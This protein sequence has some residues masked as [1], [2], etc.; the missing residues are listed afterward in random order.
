ML[1]VLLLLLKGWTTESVVCVLRDQTQRGIKI[2]VKRERMRKERQQRQQQ[3][4][5][6][7]IPS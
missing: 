7:S 1:P 6:Y 2:K 4:N 5:K 3:Q